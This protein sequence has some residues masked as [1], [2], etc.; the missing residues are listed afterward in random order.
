MK[1]EAYDV[2]YVLSIVIPSRKVTKA[3]R[4]LLKMIEKLDSYESCINEEWEKMLNKDPSQK[5]MCELGREFYEFDKTYYCKAMTESKNILF[6]CG[7][8]GELKKNKKD[9]I[10]SWFTD[11]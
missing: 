8:Y 2:L 7:K 10:M 4:N 1:E 6:V 5:Q 11:L 9:R 3:T